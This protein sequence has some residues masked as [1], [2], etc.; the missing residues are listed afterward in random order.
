MKTTGGTARMDIYRQSKQK[1]YIKLRNKLY[2]LIYDIRKTG[3]KF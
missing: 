2:F 3:S 1:N